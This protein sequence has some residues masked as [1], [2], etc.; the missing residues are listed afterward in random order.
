[1]SLGN[2]ELVQRFKGRP[3]YM[4]R[5]QKT[6]LV[7]TP[8]GGELYQ[9]TS[10]ILSGG[11]CRIGLIRQARLDEVGLCVAVAPVR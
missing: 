1:M 10:G 5:L 4:F 9:P 3:L 8:S 7:K 11:R 6:A 2:G